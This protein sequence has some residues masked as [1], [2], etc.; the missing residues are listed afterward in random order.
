MQDIALDT[1]PNKHANANHP[2]RW[3]VLHGGAGQQRYRWSEWAARTADT[4]IRTGQWVIYQDGD[5]IELKHRCM[6]V[7]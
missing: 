1:C 3:F 2:P 6:I 7:N 5:Q 4:L